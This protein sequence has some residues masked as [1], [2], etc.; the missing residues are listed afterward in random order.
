M[1]GT[2]LSA[3]WTSART[4][5]QIDR[6]KINIY[7]CLKQKEESYRSLIDL[8]PD[9]IFTAN[10]GGQFTHINEAA[11]RLLG[12]S[13]E[14]ILGKN[15]MDFILPNDVPRL[16]AMREYLKVPGNTQVAE[17]WIKRSNGT[18]MPIEVNAKFLP[19]GRWQTFVRD[20]TERKRAEELL[21][22]QSRDLQTYAHEIEDLYNNAP[23]GYHSIDSDGTFIQMNNTE[24]RWLGYSRMEVIRRMKMADVLTPESQKIFSKEFPGFIARGSVNDLKI[25]MIR[26]DGSI[27]SVLVNATA[28]KDSSGKYLLSRSSLFDYSAQKKL[29]QELKQAL[30][31][32][33][34]FLSIAAHDLKTPLTSLSLQIQLLQKVSQDSLSLEEAV[35]KHVQQG[36]VITVPTVQLIKQAR[37]QIERLV[38]LMNDLL[39]LTRIR[40]GHLTLNPKKV[41]LVE[42]VKEAVSN[43]EAELQ[44]R[45]IQISILG[46]TSLLGDWDPNR[47]NQI[48]TNLI[49]NAIKYG[50]DKPIEIHIQATPDHKTA[51]MQ[52]KDQG[53]GIAPDFH[54]KIFERYERASESKKIA[55]LG[56]GLYITSQ[57]VAAH[58]GRIWVESKPDH[59]STFT[60][61]LPLHKY[62]IAP[63][64]E[65][66]PSNLNKIDRI[67]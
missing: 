62:A 14:E 64:G 35:A 43:F 57:A 30:S 31:A 4:L 55:G 47:M 18:Y 22:K 9:A 29:E 25:D 15:F 48:V 6:E 5:D 52:V 46:E 16:L 42:V 41:D 34:E 37:G 50:K 8:A 1:L 65:T 45:K 13:H 12:Y 49:S 10:L 60:V 53:I 36:R 3:V 32:R 17:W 54:G 66:N 19:D 51:R 39:D 20:I 28:I 26:K 21:I 40:V 59:G 67:A 23:C 38:N 2:F 44:S 56:L 61:E 27:L 63:N 7:A 33:D 58:G 11:C 24:L